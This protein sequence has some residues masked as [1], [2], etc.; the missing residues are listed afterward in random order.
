MMNEAI[1]SE[2]HSFLRERNMKASYFGRLA[3]GDSK[4]VR[5]LESGGS[6]TLTTAEKV[7]AFIAF[8][9]SEGA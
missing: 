3:C 6:I 9:K 2:I 5:R 7:R 8:R 1:L 4:M